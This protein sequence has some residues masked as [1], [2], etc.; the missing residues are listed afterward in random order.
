M[1]H[2]DIIRMI[3]KGGMGEVYLAYD[4]ICSRKVALKRIREDLSDNELLKKRFLREAKIAADLV[5]PGVVPVFTIC[6]D[7]DLVYYTM[8]YIEGYTLKSLLKS[9][10][11]CDSLPKDLAE[12]TSVGT[13][14]SI[15][16][17]ICSTIEYVHSRGILHRDLKPDNILLGLFSEVVILDWGAALSKEMKEDVLLDL[18]IP[19]PGS[20][21]S[22]MTVPGK[23]VGTPDYMAPERL[24]GAPASESTDIYALGVILYQMLTLSF[25][26]RNKKG[27]KIHV[28]NHI[29][30]PEEVAPHR[31]IPSFLSQVVMR[32]LATDPK[33][34]YTSVQALKADI[35]QH[36][37][38][39]PQWT[40]KIALHT[41]DAECWKFH[42]SI[43]LSKYFPMLEVSPALWYS[44]AISKI[45]SFSEVRLEYTLLRKGLEGGF[46]ILLPPS[47][48]V[49]H[50]DFYRGYGFWLHIKKNVL[51]VSLVRNGLEIQKTSGN[52]DV[53][54]EK[55][56]IA[57]EKQN[58]RLSLNIDHT[59]WMI[60]M[61]Y[62]PGRGG[63]IGVIIQ[64]ITDVCGN[65]VVLESSGALHVSCLAVPDAF[66]NEKLYD[67]A[68][69][70]YRRIVESF[71]GRKEGYEAQFR[72]GIAVLEKAAEEGDQE[73]F[74]QAL[75]EFSVLHDSVAAPLEYLGKAL[76]YQRLEEYNE[77][78]KSLLLA[79]KRYGQR[80]E[81]SRVRDHVVDRLHEALYSNH[82]VSLVFMLLA[83]HV[84]P[85]SINSSEEEHFLKN[86][87]GKIHDTLFCSLDISPIDFRSSKMELLLSYWSGFTPFLPGLFQRSWDL[88][89]YRALADIFY[90][91]AD[92]GEREFIDVYGNTL[93]ENIQ[94]TTFTE[95]IVEIFPH[96][97][98]H[99]LSAL[100]AIFLHA[101]VEK[102][103]SDVDILDPVLIIYLFNLFAK[104]VLIHGKGEQILDAIQVLETYVSPQQRHTYLL[105]YEILAY[106]WMKEGKKVHE[107]LSAHYDE[108]FWIEDSHWAFV[109]YGYWLALTEESSLAYLHLSGCRE[110]HVAPRALI[111]L[112]CSPLGICEN[113]WSYQERRNLLLQKFIFFHCLGD[114]VE[115][116]NCRVAYDLL[117][118][119]RLL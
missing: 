1:Q 72:I 13:F 85:E 9:V 116:D 80:P 57:F 97:L 7:S 93:R 55:F 40:P 32:A 103:F 60:H 4:P 99:F 41:Q 78:V 8:P 73:G 109:L 19:M 86:L 105:P 53:N 59:V 54:Q 68:I 62:L 65:I 100:D 118:K 102:I 58:H 49:D 39:S 104:D 81:I 50:G 108:S 2:Y 23:I 89:D 77:E 12:Q 94:A 37:Q 88:K 119:E 70:F 92:L 114:D 11:Q 30:S 48:N 28:P 47:E 29:I 52:I 31:E 27:K 75:R 16:H 18:D 111:G 69:T 91:A 51:S 6:S 67:R 14:L 45:E 56:F 5:H 101:P 26:Y 43:L 115:R 61:D 110:D 76:V 46:G 117:V 66:L 36:L 107:L 96:Q 106:L 71:P 22:N 44:L 10:W 20:M 35:E 38:G 3:G 113:Q 15:F 87:Q 63:R 74:S 83:L 42:E 21:F 82:R 34:R 17:K 25:P 84:A 112:F 95:D 24:R 90:T 64:D 33:E 79:L 98:I